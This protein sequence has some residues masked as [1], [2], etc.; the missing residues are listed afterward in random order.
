MFKDLLKNTGVSS[1]DAN[2]GASE[3]K[4]SLED[5]A[6][7]NDLSPF[8]LL[9]FEAIIN[10]SLATIKIVASRKDIDIYQKCNM[11]SD[12]METIS[13]TYDYLSA[14]PVNALENIL[15]CLD[16]SKDLFVQS[17]QEEIDKLH[18]VIKVVKENEAKGIQ[19]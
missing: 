14:L 13:N 17:L 11:V 12:I 18:K 3:E 16:I 1:A 4:K 8:K 19:D 15:E 5:K 10:E 6:E 2:A 9:M 7:G